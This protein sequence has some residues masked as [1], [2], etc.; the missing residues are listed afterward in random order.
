MEILKQLYI[1][2]IYYFIIYTVRTPNKVNGLIID[3][4]FTLLLFF[5]IFFIN[6]YNIIIINIY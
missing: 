1:T 3:T 4:K 6:L 2:Y 5:I